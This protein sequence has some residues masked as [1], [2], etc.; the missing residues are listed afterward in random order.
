MPKNNG[1]TLIE[2]LIVL[3]IIGI[4]ASGAY[5]SLA[6]AKDMSR[7]NDR[8]RHEYVVNRALKQYY[9]LTGT[10][11]KSPIPLHLSMLKDELYSQTGVSLNISKYPNTDPLTYT[12]PYVGPDGVEM[13]EI[14]SLHVK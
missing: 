13:Y 4:L 6:R 12:G 7:E 8:S 3:V 11:L 9:A 5:P 2:I 1:F 14:S 10:Y